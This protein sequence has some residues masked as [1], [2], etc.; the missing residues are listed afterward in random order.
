MLTIKRNGKFIL[1]NQKLYE[2]NGFYLIS[3][4]LDNCIITFGVEIK[5]Q[6][7]FLIGSIKN[8]QKDILLYIESNS[9]NFGKLF[10][11]DKRIQIKEQKT[12]NNG[13]VET[14]Y[15]NNS[16]VFFKDDANLEFEIFLNF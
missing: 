4:I 15:T 1:N 12:L 9:K 10:P 2:K 6:N 14:C 5:G 11:I 7:C 16:I 3:K 8:M 13:K